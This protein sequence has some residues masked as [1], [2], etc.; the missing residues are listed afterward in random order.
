MTGVH[1]SVALATYNGA[2]FLEAQLQSL[3]AQKLLPFERVACDDG[4]QDDT[5]VIL[6]EFQQVAPFPVRIVQ[7]AERLG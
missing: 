5:L 4:S 3:L 7:N 2:R 1:V 6:A